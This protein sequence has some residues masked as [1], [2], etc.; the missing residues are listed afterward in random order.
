MLI[1]NISV[2]C[3]AMIISLGK[4]KE[5]NAPILRYGCELIIT[6]TLGLLILIVLSSLI[7]HPLAWL[8]FVMSF[9]PHRVFSGGYHADTHTRCYSVTSAMFVIGTVFSAVIKWRPHFYILIAFF[10]AVLVFFM[11]PLAAVNKPLCSQ[12]YELN[13][14]RSV[15]IVF[16]NFCIAMLFFVMD[17][18]S[19]HINIY[20]SGIFFAAMSLIMGKIKISMKEGRTNEKPIYEYCCKAYGCCGNLSNFHRNH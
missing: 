9:A 14:R 20:F 1:S 18:T 15:I 6:S 2:K 13:R 19:I 10:S 7:G 4:L 3:A 17:L 12:R 11:S 5:I 8:F 16:T